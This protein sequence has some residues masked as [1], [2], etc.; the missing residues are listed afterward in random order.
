MKNYEFLII[1]SDVHND[2]IEESWGGGYLRDHRETKYPSFIFG[3]L[4]ICVD[5]NLKNQKTRR[6]CRQTDAD[7]QTRHLRFFFSNTLLKTSKQNS[8]QK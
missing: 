1:P 8:P 4:H 2:P 7:V 3:G 5:I 6:E